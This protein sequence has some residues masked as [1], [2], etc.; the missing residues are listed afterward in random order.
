MFHIR[1][2]FSSLDRSF[3]LSSEFSSINKQDLNVCRWPFQCKK[4]VLQYVPPIL[5]NAEKFLETTD[6]C[7]AIYACKNSEDHITS[8]LAD[9]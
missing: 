1:L 3:S 7:T 4:L 8:T 9:M 6:V 5:I 2:G